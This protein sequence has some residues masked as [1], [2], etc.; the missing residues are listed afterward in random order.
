VRA[1]TTLV[2]R[3]LDLDGVSVTG[4]DLDGLDGG[5]PV[6]VQVASRR[7]VLACPHCSFRTRHRYDPVTWTRA[8]GILTW[9][10]TGW[11]WRCGGAGWPVRS[12][13]W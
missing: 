13:G 7:R 6:L 1:T 8:G 10:D 3:V 4:V 2:N 12:M 11:C 9:A 5:G